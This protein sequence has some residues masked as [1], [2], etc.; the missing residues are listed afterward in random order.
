MST[1]K[2]TEFRFISRNK[3]ILSSE[4]AARFS[5]AE[6]Y[7]VRKLGHTLLFVYDEIT[8][9]WNC[10]G[11]LRIKVSF[12]SIVLQLYKLIEI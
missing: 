8:V 10:N 9:E 1:K 5:E 6:I 11:E 3:I 12:F 4:Q 7:G 2:C